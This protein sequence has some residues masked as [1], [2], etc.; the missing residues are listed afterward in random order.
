MSANKKIRLKIIGFMTLAGALILTYLFTAEPRP[1]IFYRPV[2]LEKA[3]TES[4]FYRQYT[5][6]RHERKEWTKNPALV[7]EWLTL[8][9]NHFEV[10]TDTEYSGDAKISVYRNGENH[11]TVIILRDPIIGDDSVAGEEVRIDLRRAA[12]NSWDVEFEGWRWRCHQER[13]GF[14]WWTRFSLCA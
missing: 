11:A 10:A 5:E 8:G 3:M 7:A 2:E 1:Q 6:K 9:G 4:K 14:G 13:S 12:D